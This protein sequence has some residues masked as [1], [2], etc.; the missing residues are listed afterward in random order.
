LKK[1]RK[2]ED[3]GLRCVKNIGKG[4]KRGGDHSGITTCQGGRWVPG[5][6]EW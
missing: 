6:F 1:A 2:Y 4:E 5:S 3:D